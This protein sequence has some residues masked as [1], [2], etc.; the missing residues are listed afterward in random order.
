MSPTAIIRDEK[1]IIE[2]WTHVASMKRRPRQFTEAVA[3]RLGV[4]VRTLQRTIAKFEIRG[5]LEHIYYA[6]GEASARNGHEPKSPK[7]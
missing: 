1:Q 5:I 2:A 3:K 7:E 6:R 4:T